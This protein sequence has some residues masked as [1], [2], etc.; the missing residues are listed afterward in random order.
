MGVTGALL[1]CRLLTVPGRQSLL[2]GGRRTFGR[3][4]GKNLPEPKEDGVWE[5][6]PADLA[7]FRRLPRIG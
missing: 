2:A 3:V 1:G 7:V 5:N 6:K 4:G